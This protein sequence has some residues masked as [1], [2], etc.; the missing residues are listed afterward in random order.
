MTSLVM[1]IQFV[2]IVAL[3]GVG[4]GSFIHVST[5]RPLTTPAPTRPTYQPHIDAIDGLL[6]ALSRDGLTLVVSVDFP[7]LH[8]YQRLPSGSFGDPTNF[9]AD[10]A[11]DDYYWD[12]EL[13]K[14][15]TT[16]SIR[17]LTN[18]TTG[19]SI[20][21]IYTGQPPA[22]WVKQIS[23]DGTD[24]SQTW[25]LG[26]SLTDDG[27]YLL[28]RVRV[29]GGYSLVR[30]QSP[31]WSPVPTTTITSSLI[32]HIAQSTDHIVVNYLVNDST[33]ATLIY[34]GGSTFYYTGVEFYPTH[35]TTDSALVYNGRQIAI[36]HGLPPWTTTEFLDANPNKLRIY[37]GTAW[38]DEMVIVGTCATTLAMDDQ[39]QVYLIGNITAT[40]F[41]I[42]TYYNGQWTSTLKTF[43]SL[44]QIQGITNCQD[45]KQG[46]VD[47]YG[48]VY[49]FQV[50]NVIVIITL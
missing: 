6:P 14:D 23:M 46:R 44:A 1:L 5:K 10:A 12:V 29:D 34:P 22:G 4:L 13:S 18:E 32:L 17:I 49:V 27:Q 36:I 45:V 42:N 47:A 25:G 8:V 19:E 39:G 11:A 21:N 31:T 43:P 26:D 15:A 38:S 50:I 30:Y 41:G 20:T 3:F 9:T 35:F 16:M 48:S 37:S 28:Q 2:M 7:I 40:T 24:D 33:T